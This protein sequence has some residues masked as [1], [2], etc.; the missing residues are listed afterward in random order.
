[1]SNTLDGIFLAVGEVVGGVDHPT[2]AGLV[3][4]HLAD[5]I[6]DRVPH[7]HIGR[8]HVDFG[9]QY[10]F[11]LVELSCLHARQQI[12]V[13]LHAAVAVWAVPA[14][15]G[16]RATVLPGLLGSEIA[17]VSVALLHQVYRPVVELLEIR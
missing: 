17:D 10:F 6:Q 9:A 5:A 8:G 7:I 4:C 15:L 11:A 14:G 16:K 2:V 13:L 12:Q 3:M 1:M